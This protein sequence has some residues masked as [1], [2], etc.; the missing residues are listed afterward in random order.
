MHSTAAGLEGVV[1]S[2]GESQ[3]PLAFWV[4]V[5][6]LR[7][8]ITFKGTNALWNQ[9]GMDMSYILYVSSEI[10]TCLK[11]LNPLDGESFVLWLLPVF[12]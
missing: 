3:V 9:G 7:Q 2:V 1:A 10:E 5:P 8:F 11:P 6:F 4:V 12:Q